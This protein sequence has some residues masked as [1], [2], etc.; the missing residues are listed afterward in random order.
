VPVASTLAAGIYNIALTY[1][2]DS[3]Y[4]AA[5]GITVTLQVGQ[6]AQTISFSSATPVTY[7][8]SPIALSATAS[9][10]SLTA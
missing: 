8:V 7:G 9:S 6:I 10:R 3:N 5:T 4:A 1:G 2:G